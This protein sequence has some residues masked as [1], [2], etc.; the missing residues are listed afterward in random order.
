[1]EIVSSVWLKKTKKRRKEAGDCLS[2]FL[3][4][5][6]L[7]VPF[8]SL[9]LNQSHDLKSIGRRE[10]RSI[11]VVFDSSKL[12]LPIRET[13]NYPFWQDVLLKL[14][15]A[16]AL[17]D[18]RSHNCR[19]RSTCSLKEFKLSCL[20]GTAIGTY[21]FNTFRMGH[22]WSKTYDCTLNK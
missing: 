2:L 14:F 6:S 9:S 22:K 17:V 11:F 18:N 16:S 3:Y 13:K 20:R 19:Y 4:N 5:S 15:L 12:E 10:R 21:A 8:S 7:I 1:M